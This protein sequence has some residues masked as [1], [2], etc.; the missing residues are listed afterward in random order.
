MSPG[1]IKFFKAENL[2]VN[3]GHIFDV[4]FLDF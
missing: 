1:V 3:K 4:M 2:P